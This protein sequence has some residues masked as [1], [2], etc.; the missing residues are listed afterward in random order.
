MARA[1]GPSI[2]MN[3][4]Q[5]RD[6]CTAKHSHK[7]EKEFKFTANFKQEPGEPGD[8]SVGY[9]YLIFARFYRRL[10]YLN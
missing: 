7:L 1:A 8:I 2:F 4:V 9:F 6:C 3:A 10:H 5:N